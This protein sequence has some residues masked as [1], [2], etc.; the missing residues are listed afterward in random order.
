MHSSGVFRNRRFLLL[1]SGN[2]FS[3]LG[4]SAV[5]IAYPLAALAISGSPTWAG[6]ITLAGFLPGLL[7]QIPAGLL[8]DA[9]NRRL[10]MLACQSLGLVAACAVVFALAF[11]VPYILPLIFVCSFIEGSAF[12]VFDIAQ[13]AAIRDVTEESQRASAYSFYE[14]EQPISNLVGRAIGG[15]LYGVERWLP[16]A[17][18]AVSYVFCLL[19]LLLMPGALFRPLRTSTKSP[20][21]ESFWFR[22]SDGLKR[23]WKTP[24]LRLSTF[25]TSVNNIVIQTAILLVLVVSTDRGSPPWTIGLILAC[26]GVGGIGG[27]FVASWL[28]RRTR[29]RVLFAACVWGWTISFLVIAVSKNPFIL[30]LA[31][32]GLGWVGTVN[33]VALTMARVRAVP[34]A[35]LGRI[36]GAGSMVT[37]GS[38]AAGALLAGYVLAAY[39]PNVVGWILFGTMLLLAVAVSNWTSRSGYSK[40]GIWS[41]PEDQSHGRLLPSTSGAVPPSGESDPADTLGKV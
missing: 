33:S 16:F 4:S 12:A 5:R 2:A 40:S 3:L 29:P 24:I 19:T 20:S 41:T 13:V 14:A 25:T 1:W 6:W 17:A 36:V 30:A 23:T 32:F 26:A 7:F 39:D 38:M 31:W 34:Q 35:E 9:A 11:Q 15:A 8:V 22:M 18:N 27:S 28:D 21:P 10:I 37:D